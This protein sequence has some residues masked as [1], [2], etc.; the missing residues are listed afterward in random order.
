VLQFHP[1]RWGETVKSPRTLTNEEAM[2]NFIC[3][4]CGTQFP[5][6][7]QPPADCHICQ[8][9]RQYVNQQGQQWTTLAQ[10]QADHHNDVTEIEPG[11]FGI[12][13]DPRIAIGQQAHLIQ[14]KTGNVLWDCVS[15]L[16]DATVA[17]V[18]QL[19]GIV[20]IAI[21]HPHFFSSM[22]EWSRAF[23]APIVL[24]ADNR[25]WVTRP[26]DAIVFWEGDTH[27]LMPG[28]TV[29]RCGGHFPGSSVLHWNA[30]A[31]GKGS[32][33][34][35]DTIY[36]VSDPRFVSFMYSYPNLIPLNASAVRRIV[37]AVEPFTF[38]RLYAAWHGQMVVSDAKQAVRRSAERYIAHITE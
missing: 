8:D 21:S 13:S 29:I 34:T 37:E 38:D 10:L 20:A 22:V 27:E 19:G 28:L 36:V 25:A 32:L 9:Y 24:H 2:T 1:M 7:E 23:D 15:L 14:G 6:S 31:G 12:W 11:L 30:G 17:R 5:E 26:D 18:K 3:T 16:D 4:T 33:F 35:G